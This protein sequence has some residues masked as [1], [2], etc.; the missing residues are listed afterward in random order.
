MSK[1]MLYSRI[2]NKY[3]GGLK[4]IQKQITKTKMD[5][6]L[7]AKLLASAIGLFLLGWFMVNLAFT[8]DQS[9][10]YREDLEAELA[11]R[12][13]IQIE[14]DTL[15]EKAKQSDM[16]IEGLE[17]V[18]N[19][20]EPKVE[21]DE[22]IGNFTHTS[23]GIDEFLRVNGADFV[24]E[25]GDIFRAAG[26]LYKVKPELL[27][28]IAQADSSL[29]NHLRTSNNVGNVG[30]TESS[31]RAYDSLGEAVGAM[32]QTLNNQYLK[33][34]TM[35]G[36]LSQGGRNIIGTKYSCSNAPSPYKCYAMSPQHW[37]FNVTKCLQ[38]ILQD[39]S[40]DETFEFRT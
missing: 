18:V 20:Y 36:Q 27:V 2:K 22:T 8:V 25:S 29:G 9:L 7:Q 3:K 17:M 11:N 32:G 13:T 19:S 30:N 6:K 16:K 26:L 35:V 34:N 31:S 38:D 28:C 40:I 5:K 4:Y 10:A 12:Q 23:G 21:V 39:E 33:G 1:C 14:L 24:K 15:N 37:D